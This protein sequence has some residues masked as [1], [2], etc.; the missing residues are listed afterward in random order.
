MALWKKVDTSPECGAFKEKEGGECVL[1]RQ[2]T[3]SAPSKRLH[4][5]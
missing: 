4:S 2:S 1:I 3:K 5:A